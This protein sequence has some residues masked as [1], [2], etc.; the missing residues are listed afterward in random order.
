MDL[1]TEG[2]TKQL[3]SKAVNTKKCQDCGSKFD[4]KNIRF[5]CGS[6]KKFFCKRC[7]ASDK[8]VFKD[9]RSVTPERPVCRSRPV[10]ELIKK[11]S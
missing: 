9:A 10:A 11:H 8:W 3:I 6:S 4:F 1:T 5:Y 7:V 2:K